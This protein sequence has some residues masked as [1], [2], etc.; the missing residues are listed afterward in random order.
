M[1]RSTVLALK[2]QKPVENWYAGSQNYENISEKITNP[3]ARARGLIE[4]QPA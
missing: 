2:T 3:T 4:G 1:V